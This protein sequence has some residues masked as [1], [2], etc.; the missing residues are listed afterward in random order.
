MRSMTITTVLGL[1]LAG[2]CGPRTETDGDGDG[3]GSG[4]GTENGNDSTVSPS[5]TSVATVG[6]DSTAT[7]GGELLPGSCTCRE[8]SEDAPECSDLART[9]CEGTLICPELVVEC[10]R[11]NPSMYAC[12]SEYEYDEG[13]L[14]CALAALRDRTPGKLAVDAEND[15]CGFEGCGSHQT[16]ITI[17]ADDLAVVRSCSASPISA[18]SSSS[19]L[20]ALAEPA[21]FDGCLGLASPAERYDCLFD[22]L[23]ETAELCG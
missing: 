5:G 12:K 19:S 4:G 18:E 13:A 22:G 21:H 3:G 16:E 7:T 2:A 9:Q 14:A 10:P 6:A 1:A 8:P 23:T 20:D 17:L 11:V 15:I